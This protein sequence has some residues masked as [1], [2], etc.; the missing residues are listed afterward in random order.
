MKNRKVFFPED[1]P[2]SGIDRKELAGKVMAEFR[3]NKTID[4]LSALYQPGMKQKELVLA[5]SK[6]LRTVKAYW[7]KDDEG[8]IYFKRPEVKPKKK[9][10]KP[11]VPQC[12]PYMPEPLSPEAIASIVTNL[13]Q[14]PGYKRCESPK[15]GNVQP[16]TLKEDT[17]RHNYQEGVDKEG[18][19]F[20]T[21]EYNGKLSPS[22]P[23]PEEPL[24]ELTEEAMRG[25]EEISTDEG[26]KKYEAERFAAWEAK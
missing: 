12:A 8:N 26:W 22:M 3:A 9:K 2:L 15:P 20:R 10:Q 23:K 5:S 18:N 13:E 7:N 21:L 1:S 16:T 17:T 4:L 14:F 19:K 24:L 11:G 25:F 6:S